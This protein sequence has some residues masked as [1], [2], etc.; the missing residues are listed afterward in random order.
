MPQ[1]ALTCLTHSL[2]LH[3]HTHHTP[4]AAPTTSITVIDRMSQKY[5]VRIFRLTGCLCSCPGG[6]RPIVYTC[7]GQRET[8]S[9]EGEIGDTGWMKSGSRSAVYWE[10]E[11]NLKLSLSSTEPCN[12][13]TPEEAASNCH[14]KYMCL[15]EQACFTGEQKARAIL[16]WH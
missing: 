15:R 7:A 12:T 13:Q 10:A 11:R 2:S 3:T 16:V 6:M 14:K 1:M 8:R 4:P 5:I 9:Y